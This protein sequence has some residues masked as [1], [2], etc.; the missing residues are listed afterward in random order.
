MYL[1]LETDHLQQ[2]SMKKRVALQLEM[3][4]IHLFLSK[5]PLTKG[6]N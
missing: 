6:W 5:L 4:A 3:L 1:K 2:S